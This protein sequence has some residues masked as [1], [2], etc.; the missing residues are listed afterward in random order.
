M[1]DGGLFSSIHCL[2]ATLEAS[3]NSG[4]SIEL[5]MSKKIKIMTTG[6]SIKTYSSDN[7]VIFDGLCLFTKI[8]GKFGLVVWT[9]FGNDG[10]SICLPHSRGLSTIVESCM[11]SSIKKI[12]SRSS[13]NKITFIFIVA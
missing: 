7:L 8:D 6:I 2:E 4:L 9:K 13:L 12:L 5:P 11:T 1:E 10:F 3:Q